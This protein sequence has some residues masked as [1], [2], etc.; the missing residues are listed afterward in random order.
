MD[1]TAPAVSAHT[2]RLDAIV[3]HGSASAR[4]HG[5]SAASALASPA[6]AATAAA[7]SCVAA[8][9]L[10]GSATS[11]VVA[12]MAAAATSSTSAS[13][14]GHSP[15]GQSSGVGGSSRPTAAHSAASTTPAAPYKMNASGQPY[16]SMSA[17][18]AAYAATVPTL[19][20]ACSNPQNLDRYSAG[21]Q[22][23]AMA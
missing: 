13:G 4:A 10:G 17:G 15:P 19:K 5:P 11:V 8:A 1:A 3:P 12:A 7:A 9:A 16:A 6:A 2:G 14:S 23:A 21:T 18:D 22:R 20:H